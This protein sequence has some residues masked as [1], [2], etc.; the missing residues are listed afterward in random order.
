MLL[1]FYRSPIYKY[2]IFGDCWIP[3]V[4]NYTHFC[5]RGIIYSENVRNKS[6]EGAYYMGASNLSGKLYHC[7]MCIYRGNIMAGFVYDLYP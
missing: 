6:E 5:G 1:Y 4:D 3:Y 2:N 7:T